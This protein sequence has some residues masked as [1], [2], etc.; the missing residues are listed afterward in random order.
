MAIF[1]VVEKR[2]EWKE[3]V[4]LEIAGHLVFLDKSGINTDQTCL[5]G[6]VSSTQRTI[7]YALL[8]TPKTTVVHSSIRLDGEKIFTINQSGMTGTHFVQYLKETLL[9]NL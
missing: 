8:N 5:Y 7:D 1:N 9:S 4:T 3:M 6:R 2:K